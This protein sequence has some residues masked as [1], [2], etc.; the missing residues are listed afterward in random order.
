[1]G[2]PWGFKFPNKF[3]LILY[4]CTFR[5][6]FCMY[7]RTLRK[8]RNMRGAVSLLRQNLGFS[9]LHSKS[10]STFE[11]FSLKN[12]DEPIQLA[13]EFE[14]EKPR[15]RFFQYSRSGDNSKHL[16][17]VSENGVKYIDLSSVSC[18]ASDMIQFIQQKYC[19]ENLLEST[20]YM[21]VND[22]KDDVR[23]LPPIQSPG[24][25]IGVKHNYPDSCKEENQKIPLVPEFYIKFNSSITG[26]LDNIRAHR[27]AKVNTSLFSFDPDLK[28]IK[29]Q[30]IDY[31]CQVAVVIGTECR[32]VTRKSAMGC[33]FGYMIAQDITARDWKVMLGGQTLLCKSLDS[34]CPLGP[35]LVHK[36]HVPD[37]N[38]LW[39]KTIIN[40]EEKQNGNTKNMIFKIDYL[41]YRLSQ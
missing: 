5:D 22:V 14:Y 37:I 17:M 30:R 24:K 3:T 23:L 35:V 4:V 7:K 1:M 11:R 21:D 2:V 40:G 25:I 13:N 31:G 34:F 8:P 26:A 18:A 10:A 16:G 41:I 12:K 33:V 19:M 39:I 20:Q 6:G 32:N 28:S 29:L 36:C 27:I 15:C 38:N 9:R